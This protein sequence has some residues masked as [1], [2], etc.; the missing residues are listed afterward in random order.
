MFVYVFLFI[1]YVLF[2]Y[3]HIANLEIE[4]ICEYAT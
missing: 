4:S 3:F 2:L 1:G